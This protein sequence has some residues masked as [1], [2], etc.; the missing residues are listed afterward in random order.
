ML[1]SISVVFCSLTSTQVTIPPFFPEKMQHIDQVF[2]FLTSFF[3]LPL[4][5]IAEDRKDYSL[6]TSSSPENSAQSFSLFIKYSGMI[7][8]AI[9]MLLAL[10][11]TP[12]SESNFIPIDP[13]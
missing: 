12:I 13:F 4:L 8:F 11:V 10:T 5:K 6:T 1:V 9:G 2:G 7:R 3:V